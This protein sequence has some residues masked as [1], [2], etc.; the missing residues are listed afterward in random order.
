[1]TK[2]VRRKII[3]LIEAKLADRM[4]FRSVTLGP[5]SPTFP[6]GHETPSVYLTREVETM[7][8]LTNEQKNSTF[9]IEIIA[10][11]ESA[12][13]LELEKADAQDEIEEALMELQTEASFAALATMISV[14]S[15]DGS[16]AALARIGLDV[17]VLPPFGLIRVS[18]E[19]DFRYDAI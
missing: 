4:Y 17:Q 9:P 8:P 3:K 7:T 5:P 11:V 10:L 15:A 1:M 12:S 6:Q 16:P 14:D 13:E 19:I 2:G 18:A